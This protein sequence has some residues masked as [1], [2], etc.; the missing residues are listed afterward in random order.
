M[1]SEGAFLP[2]LVGCSIVLPNDTKTFLFIHG[3]L[4][5]ILKS[6]DV[7]ICCLIKLI[8]TILNYFSSGPLARVDRNC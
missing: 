3:R 6:V 8:D 7:M 2:L 5:G 4:V 1:P